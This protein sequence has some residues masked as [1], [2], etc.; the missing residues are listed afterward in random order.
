MAET[1]HFAILHA[2]TVEITQ[3]H[4]AAHAA[5]YPTECIEGI[6]RSASQFRASASRLV[7][8]Q[9][10][11]RDD[12]F[13]APSLSLGVPFMQFIGRDFRA[14]Q[15]HRSRNVLGK[16]LMEQMFGDQN[17]LA[18]SAKFREFL[19]CCVPLYTGGKN[20]QLFS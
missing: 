10:T 19:P 20:S 1:R 6:V 9:A 4:N 15:D 18:V 5:I 2:Q 17:R 7:F 11:F 13:C 3:F 16:S 14:A 8:H 12:L